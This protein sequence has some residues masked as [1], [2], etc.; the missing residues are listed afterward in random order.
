MKSREVRKRLKRVVSSFMIIAMLVTIMPISPRDWSFAVP[1]GDEIDV[2]SIRFVREHNGFNTVGAYVEIAGSGLQGKT[3]RFEKAGLGGGFEEIG[4]KVID[5]DTFVKFTFEPEDAEVLA[6][7]MRIG[8]SEIDLGLETFPN[9][10]AIDQQNINLSKYGETP[11]NS[12]AVLTITGNNLDQIGTVTSGSSIT[13]KYGRVQSRQID[14]TQSYVD[15]SPD[16]SSVTLTEPPLPGEKGF[17][18]IIIEKQDTTAGYTTSVEYL[19]ANSFRFMEDL[20]LTEPLMFPNTGAKEDFVYFTAPNF[21][22]TKNYDAYFLKTLDGSDQF[23]EDNKAEYVALELGELPEDEDRL[24]VK[25]PDDPDFELRSYYVVLTNTVNDEIIAEQ[26]ILNSE[27]NPD[28]FTVI[29]S[30][31][32]PTIESI[33]PQKGPDTGS[34]VQISG[35]NILTLNLPDLEGSGDFKTVTAPDQNPSGKDNNKTLEIEYDETG[36]T[37]KGQAAT[38]VRNI[39]VQ[40]GKETYFVQ[41][42]TAHSM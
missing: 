30:G 11:T 12:D 19:Y 36:M 35:R 24:I 16:Y 3:I 2:T 8:T 41:N 20:G 21:V 37:Y 18:N 23:S 32:Q 29:G 28:Q 10:S 13:A 25:V 38:T 17:Q 40:I 4:E 5:E 1:V 22:D 33:F 42:P 14:S 6:G 34:N 7:A 31:F 26:V 27:G 39:K 9:L 15:F